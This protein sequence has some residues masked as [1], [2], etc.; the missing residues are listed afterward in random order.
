MS[1]ARGCRRAQRWH[2]DH[3][4]LPVPSVADQPRTDRNSFLSRGQ[5]LGSSPHAYSVERRSRAK[6]C[7]CPNGKSCRGSSGSN[8]MSI[9]AFGGT[10]CC[11]EPIFSGLTAPS[12]FGDSDVLNGAPGLGYGASSFAIHRDRALKRIS[13]L[14]DHHRP[15]TIR[16][17]LGNGSLLDRCNDHPGANL[18]GS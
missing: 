7:G 18:Y 8:I 3:Y 16:L 5:Q 1:L 9:R 4:S 14:R 12:W 10:S 13:G 15:R 11:C 17:R 6:S 2:G